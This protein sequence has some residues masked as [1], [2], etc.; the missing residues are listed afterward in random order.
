MHLNTDKVTNSVRED[1]G[2]DLGGDGG[3]SLVPEGHGCHICVTLQYFL[4][5]FNGAP[6]VLKR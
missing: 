3:L 2:G 4:Q 5:F 6:R 1:S